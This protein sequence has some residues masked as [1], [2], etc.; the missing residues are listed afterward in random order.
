MA[1]PPDPVIEVDGVTKRY[2]DLT[3]VDDVSLTVPNGEVVG[4]LGPNGA[5]KTTLIKTILGLIIPTDGTVRVAGNN[6]HQRP[7]RAY[8]TVGAMLEGA[9]NVYWRLSVRENLAYFAALGGQAVDPEDHDELLE[10]FNLMDKAD[11]PLNELSRGQKQKVSLACTLVRDT[12]VVFLDEPTLGLDVEASHELRR[13]LRRLVSDESLT[14]VLSSHDMDVM[15]EVCDRVVILSDGSV[16]ADETIDDLMGLFRTRAYRITVEGTVPASVRDAIRSRFDPDDW[17]TNE[18]Y[19]TLEVTI[20]DDDS[21]Y[22]VLSVLAE[23]SCPLE[24][25]ESMEPDLEEVF[26]EMTNDT[27]TRASATPRGIRPV[28]AGGD[29]S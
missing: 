4:L 25:I 10:R 20:A 2:G 15:E 3:A 1:D 22:D 23:A 27:P 24:D 21:V 14:V 18:E 19:T 12:D 28:S 6:V 26:L 7:K 8:G 17:S 29:A 13:E 5:G 16:I 11:E 9:R